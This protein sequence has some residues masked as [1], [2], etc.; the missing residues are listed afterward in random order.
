MHQQSSA[1]SAA[2][3]AGISQRVQRFRSALK[4]SLAIQQE[5]S[6]AARVIVPLW[7]A[8]RQVESAGGQLYP[9]GFARG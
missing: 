3:A 2:L 7:H 9:P 8:L 6:K 4:R 5:T 1:N